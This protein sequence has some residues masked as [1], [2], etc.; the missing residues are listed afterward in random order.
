LIAKEFES[1][2]SKEMWTAS[3]F[4]LV[5]EQTY[6]VSLIMLSRCHSSKWLLLSALEI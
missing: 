3:K 1:T 2:N 4:L 5:L 6:L